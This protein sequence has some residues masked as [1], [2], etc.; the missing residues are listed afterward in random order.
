[1]VLSEEALPGKEKQR[2]EEIDSATM[3]EGRTRGREY[4]LLYELNLA[5]LSSTTN[6]EIKCMDWDQF[7]SSNVIGTVKWPL[8]EIIQKY[9]LSFLVCILSCWPTHFSLMAGQ[10]QAAGTHW[11]LPLDRP[12]QERC[13]LNLVIVQRV[14]W[15]QFRPDISKKKTNQL[16]HNNILLSKLLL[17]SIE[18]NGGRE[19]KSHKRQI[20]SGSVFRS[21]VGHC[22]THMGRP[23]LKQKKSEQTLA[24]ASKHPNKQQEMYTQDVLHTFLFWLFL[25]F[26]G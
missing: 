26:H 3:G 12:P 25:F 19:K 18:F 9:A 7:R 6:L 22:W 15:C 16:H 17:F 24:L 21:L 10:P 13:K 2:E 5:D 14:S 1:M 20:V 11:S 23:D 4:L 8:G